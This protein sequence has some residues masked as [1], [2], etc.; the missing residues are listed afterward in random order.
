MNIER[1]ERAVVE[2]VLSIS[3][4]IASV[5]VLHT[6]PIT[7]PSPAKGGYYHEVIVIGKRKEI[8]G[9]SVQ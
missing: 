6:L 1:V 2:R 4:A 9:G 3:P 5:E 8:P 7:L